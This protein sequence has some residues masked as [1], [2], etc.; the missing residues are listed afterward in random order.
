MPWQVPHDQGAHHIY[1]SAAQLNM[2]LRS[3]VHLFGKYLFGHEWMEGK[4]CVISLEGNFTK[5]S[6]DNYVYISMIVIIY[7]DL[8]TNG[9]YILQNLKGIWARGPTFFCC[10]FTKPRKKLA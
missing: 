6:S 10:F 7:I 5:K 9:R 4:E 3:L 8:L 2:Y 1:G